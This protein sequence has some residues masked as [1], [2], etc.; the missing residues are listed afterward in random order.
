MLRRPSSR[1]RG[2]S[3]LGDWL[4]HRGFTQAEMFR[5]FEISDGCVA[6]ASTV[7]VPR[8]GDGQGSRHWY[9]GTVSAEEKPSRL[10]ADPS[11]QGF[12]L[13]ALGDHEQGPQCFGGHSR[14]GC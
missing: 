7:A 5:E 4:A 13:E 6:L 14:R 8:Q 3:R 1:R 11:S 10:G 12:V 9:S 2:S